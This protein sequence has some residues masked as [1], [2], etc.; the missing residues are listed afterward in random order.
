[1]ENV[2]AT[3]NEAAP[4]VSRPIRASTADA[5]AEAEI[6][7]FNLLIDALKL[8]G[9]DT[10]FRSAGHSDHGPDAQGAGARHS[11]H[12]V[13]PRA[14]RRLRRIDRGLHHAESPAS[15]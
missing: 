1:M 9:I 2:T 11:R 10:I 15:A 3:R 13:S 6:D 8:N 7:G 5:Q 12:L 4:A 14:E